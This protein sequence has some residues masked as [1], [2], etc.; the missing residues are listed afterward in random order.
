V[1]RKRIEVRGGEVAKA[2]ACK[3]DIVPLLFDKLGVLEGARGTLTLQLFR[4]RDGG[5]MIFNEI[6]ARFGGGYPL[7]RHAGADFQEWLIREYLEDRD[8]PLCHDWTDGA[9]MLRY[10]NEVIVLPE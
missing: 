8:A 3:N 10:D 4:P 2:Q 6:N 7:S 9:I 1:P 5:E